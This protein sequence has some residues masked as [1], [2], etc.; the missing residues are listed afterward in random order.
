MVSYRRIAG[1]A[2]TA[3]CRCF[4]AAK[5]AAHRVLTCWPAPMTHTPSS[6]PQR[7]AERR[8]PEMPNLLQVSP[9]INFSPTAWTLWGGNEAPLS[10]PTQIRAYRTAWDPIPRAV[11]AV[12]P[13]AG[14]LPYPT[15]GPPPSSTLRRSQS[16][17]ETN[18]CAS[19]KSLLVVVGGTWC[20]FS[21]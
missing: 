16:Q 18:T 12:T 4:G 19:C 13:S 21:R 6:V 9:A 15:A 14:A 17:T 20:V 7:R 1:R 10:L 3:G 8:G 11:I 5:S 2:L